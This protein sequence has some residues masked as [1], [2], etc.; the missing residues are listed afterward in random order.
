MSMTKADLAQILKEIDEPLTDYIN[1]CGSC[2]R[3]FAFTA[4]EATCPHCDD[5][6]M[7]PFSAYL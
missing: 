3:L 6:T 2:G 5:G 7:R 1:C 4:E